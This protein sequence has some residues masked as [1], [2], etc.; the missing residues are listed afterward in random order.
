M[1]EKIQLGKTGG[2]ECSVVYVG[3]RMKKTHEGEALSSYTCVEGF[4][5]L[6]IQSM[7][8]TAI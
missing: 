8:L 7:V 4:K 5:F 1:I 3:W 6:T 2:N